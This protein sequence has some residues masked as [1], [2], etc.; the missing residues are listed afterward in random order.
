MNMEKT[1]QKAG[2]AIAKSG[3]T[4]VFTGAGISVESGIPPFRGP[5]GLWTQYDPEFIEIE[6]FMENP[7]DSWR[8]IK[9][10]FYDHWGKATPNEAH[11]A[12]TTMQKLGWLRAVVTQNIDCL[13]QRA[14][15]HNVIEFHGSLDRLVCMKCGAITRPDPVI[16]Q[17][18]PP[19]C[20]SCGGLLKPDVVFFGEAIPEAASDESFQA[21][22]AVS[23]VIVVGTSGEVMPACM[24]PREAKRRGATVIEINPCP[25]AF[26]QG[27][28]TDIFLQG[29][30]SVLLSAILEA[31]QCV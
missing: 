1:I 8:K 2:L 6:Y 31:A 15:T 3:N 4:M 25:S 5:D 13:H 22:H 21:A 10:V 11:I 7:T 27:G 18:L 23:T 28:I 26:T 30:A 12:I 9:E 17:T 14:G 20:V 16:L 24:I 19:R 29:R